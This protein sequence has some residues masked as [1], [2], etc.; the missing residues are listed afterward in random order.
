[1]VREMLTINLLQV[2]QFLIF[3]EII[4]YLPKNE[5]FSFILRETKNLSIVRVLIF[6]NEDVVIL[7]TRYSSKKPNF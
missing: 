2:H 1:M 3:A 4:F 7:L 6:E 5:E